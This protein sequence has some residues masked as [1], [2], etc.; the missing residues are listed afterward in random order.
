MSENRDTFLESFNRCMAK[1]IWETSLD[2]DNLSIT[3]TKLIDTSQDE[4]CCG[5]YSYK[6]WDKYRLENLTSSIYPQSCC[7][8]PQTI[9]ED[10]GPYCVSVSDLYRVGCAKF[11][12]EFWSRMFLRNGILALSQLILAIFVVIYWFRKNMY[13]A[14]ESIG[15]SSNTNNCQPT[16]EMTTLERPK[17]E[18]F[19]R[20]RNNFSSQICPMQQD[21]P[22]SYSN[23]IKESRVYP[24]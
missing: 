1:Y 4:S 19:S 23:A 15:D 7:S 6:D 11:G 21:D 13:N 9:Q 12:K 20:A 5:V 10:E 17:S 3:C 2:Y 16:P 18:Q 24:L 22:P 14:V 8:S